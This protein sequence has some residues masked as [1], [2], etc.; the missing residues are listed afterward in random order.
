VRFT[1]AQDI[2]YGETLFEG[3]DKEI[4][5]LPP[6]R[7]VFHPHYCK[8]SW[9]F[10]VTTTMSA[11]FNKHNLGA[12]PETVLSPQMLIETRDESI[13]WS[14]EDD[15]ELDIEKVLTHVIQNGISDEGCNNYHGEDKIYTKGDRQAECKDCSN[16]EDS[17]TEA[18]CHFVPYFSHRLHSY[19]PIRSEEKDDQSKKYT[20][21]KNTLADKLRKTGPILCQMKLSEKVWDVQ[22]REFDPLEIEEDPKADNHFVTVVGFK[23]KLFDEKDT[24]MVQTPFSE[25][26]GY[27]GILS[28]VVPDGS[29]PYGL[30]DNCHELIIDTNPEKIKAENPQPRK[31]GIFKSDKGVKH[32]NKSSSTALGMIL[33]QGYKPSLLMGEFNEG[34]EIKKD[35]PPLDWR[36]K[37][38]RNYLTYVKN[39]H[40]PTY[41]GSCWAQAGA[42]VF[43][44][45]INI[46]NWNNGER[47]FPKLNFSVQSIINCKVGGSCL[48]GDTSLLF[49]KAKT[50]KVPIEGCNPYNAINPKNFTCKDDKI[51][52]RPLAS[53]EVKVIKP[54]ASASVTSWR[55]VRGVDAIKTELQN[56]PVEC[57]F[58]VTEEFVNFTF[59]KDG[60]L[61][62]WEK[63]IEF[64]ELNHAISVVGWGVQDG[65][66]YWIGRNSWGKEW[67]DNG[68][69]YM[70][71]GE[72]LLGIESGCLGVDVQMNK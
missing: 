53:K 29:N 19:N 38:G 64:L 33:N 16:N 36:N 12:F 56:G 13:K 46:K 37:E 28:V 27:F 4:N 43:A 59:I 30:L 50:W 55:R 52:T 39:Q 58:Q 68:F 61:V 9:A 5:I 63:N 32:T 6:V 21:L 72:N 44:D 23:E 22:S 54:I 34:L 35:L 20:E 15:S 70:K 47:I 18:K 57:S 17:T 62:L 26:V 14:C 2:F 31:K 41:C 51:C 8:A 42:S 3:H 40:I 48:G 11:L 7:S 45:R 25:N 1:S 69:F 10:A 24:F 67:G 66:E 60:K 49:E 65:V 71:M